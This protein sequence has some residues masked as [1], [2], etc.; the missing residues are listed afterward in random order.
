MGYTLLISDQHDPY[1]N[2]AIEDW[3]LRRFV[4]QQPVIFMYAN[5]PSVVIGRAQNPWKECHVAYCQQQD[6]HIV[7]RQSGGGTVYH[8]LGNLNISFICPIT[9]YDK[10]YHLELIA[11]TLRSIGYAANKNARH[12]III[13]QQGK[14]YKISGSAFRESK[15]KAFHHMTLLL[16]ANLS[17]LTKVL[18]SPLNFLASKGV[19]SV[20]SPVTNLNLARTQIVKA[21]Q[22]QAPITHLALEVV[23]MEQDYITQK[24]QMYLSWD[25]CFGKTLA[26]T[27]KHQGHIISVDNGIVTK[28]DHPGY[29]IGAC[30]YAASS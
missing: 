9:H 30:F 10:Q 23:D 11:S 15:D 29:I 3:L 14:D 27:I 21:L 26:F 13:H 17:E 24:Q 25:W 8:D 20:R 22:H 4:K 12:D 7:R 2:L 19:N 5:S 28:S 1:Y 6:I 16:Q 18:R